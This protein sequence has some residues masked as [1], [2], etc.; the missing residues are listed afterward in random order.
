MAQVKCWGF[1]YARTHFTSIPV[2]I[3]L[4]VLKYRINN[5]LVQT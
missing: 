2:Q 5:K 4:D 1:F 3:A